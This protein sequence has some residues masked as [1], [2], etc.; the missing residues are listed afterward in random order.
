MKKSN[1][2]QGLIKKAVVVAVSMPKQ[3][4]EEIEEH[5]SELEFLAETAGIHSAQRFTQKLEHPDNRT[6]VGKDRKSVV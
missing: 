3:R 5:L 6:Y 1:D 4:L 2:V